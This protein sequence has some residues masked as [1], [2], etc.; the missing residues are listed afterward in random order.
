[1][2]CQTPGLN[3][4]RQDYFIPLTRGKEAVVDS[5][6]LYDYLMQWRWHWFG[7]KNDPIRPSAEIGRAKRFRRKDD[8]PGPKI[9]MMHHAVINWMGLVVPDGQ[10]IDHI[11]RN[12]LNNRTDNLRVVSKSFNGHNTG[13]RRRLTSTSGVSSRFKGVLWSK[14][15]KKWMLRFSRFFYS[16]EEAARAWDKVAI[17]SYGKDAYTNEK[18]GLFDG[19]SKDSR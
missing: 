4:E 14:P 2:P 1:M 11:D 15:H 13:K 3:D 10:V 19:G 18:E 12:P 8:P 7:V 6:E 17:A 5:K 9:I 16:E